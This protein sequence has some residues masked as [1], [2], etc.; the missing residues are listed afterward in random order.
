V[1]TDFDVRIGAVDGVVFLDL[2]K[3][4]GGDKCFVIEVVCNG[5]AMAEFARTL[6]REIHHEQRDYHPPGLGESPKWTILRRAVPILLQVVR[7]SGLRL[8]VVRGPAE[9]ELRKIQKEQDRRTT[10][11]RKARGRRPATP[12]PHWGAST[13]RCP[14]QHDEAFESLYLTP[15]APE[16]VAR[17]VFKVLALR[18]HPDRGGSEDKMKRL[19]STWDS[20]RAKRGWA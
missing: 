13:A 20:I 15:N 19:N 2:L 10:D 16:E 18:N 17:A 14:Y 4:K 12:P 9:K 11:H 8:E 7:A 1:S 3:M 6:N 5:P